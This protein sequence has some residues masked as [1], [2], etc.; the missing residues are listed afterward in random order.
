MF[1]TFIVQ[2]ILNILFV[3]N[4][5][6]PGND[7]GIAVIL[8]TILIRFAL[9]P[10]VKKQLHSQKALTAIQPEVN[11]LKEKYKDDPQ[12]FQAA[13]MELYKE[14]EV[15]PFG[16]CLPLLLQ[17]P[18]LYGIFAL[19][20]RVGDVGFISLNGDGSIINSLYSFVGNFG[21]VKDYIASHEV[22]NTVALNV[23][24]LAKVGAPEGVSNFAA[25]YWPAV[26]LGVATGIF[27]LIQTKMMAPKKQPNDVKEDAMT[28]IT[29]N[30][31]YFFPVMIILISLGLPA[32]LSLYWVTTTLFGIGQQYLIMHQDVEE[33]EEGSERKRSK[34]SQ[35][36]SK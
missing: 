9:F 8:L 2:P 7:F 11:K 20:K 19:F 13:T 34:K 30:M 4:A 5:I 26:V 25:Y 31:M 27:Q 32:A 21:F 14:K 36:N 35:R 6:T 28:G 16:S 3:I 1:E 10:V 33:L 12:K 18:F 29:K 23:I 22:I 15:N 17:M 24:D